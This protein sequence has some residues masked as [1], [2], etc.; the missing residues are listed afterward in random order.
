MVKKWEREI[1]WRRRK[2]RR[3]KSSFLSY[4]HHHCA[5]NHFLKTAT[6]FFTMGLLQN[7]CH[8]LNA[9]LT[10]SP[11]AC[12]PFS[13][14]LTQCPSLISCHIKESIIFLCPKVHFEGATLLHYKKLLF[15]LPLSIPQNVVRKSPKERPSCRKIIGL[16]S[17]YTKTR[18]YLH[19]YWSGIH[20]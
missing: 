9:A 2:C 1:P 8:R 17:L 12:G 3:K 4:C 5:L 20:V 15:L 7:Y 16:S 14:S 13:L 19:Y 10:N 18:T 6:T 11:C